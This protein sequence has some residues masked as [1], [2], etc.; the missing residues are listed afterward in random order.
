M[1]PHVVIKPD[2]AQRF[3]DAMKNGRVI[4]FSAPC[5]FGKTTLAKALLENY[6][7]KWIC[8]TEADYKIPDLDETGWDVL[9]VEQL[10]MIHD[11]AEQQNLCTLIRN[12]P[13]RR[14]VLLSRGIPQGWILPFQL[15]GLMHV[16][17]AFDLL[18]DRKTTEK[19]L[20]TFG[21]SV[22][23]SELTAIQKDSL[24]FPASIYFLGRLMEGGNPY[25]LLLA[26]DA[27]RDVYIYFEEA[28]YHRFDL[29]MRRFLLELA[30]FEQFGPE[31]A[32]MVSGDRH[33]GELLARLQRDTTMLLYDGVE[34]FHFWPDFR[35]YL[36]WEMNREYTTEQI[37]TL[38]NRGGL[39]YELKE[40]Y[41]RALECYTKSGD[42]S[43]ISEILVK[44][45]QLHPGTGYYEEMEQYYRALPDSE[46]MGSPSLMQGMSMLCAL[47]S[48]YEGSERWYYALL[49][50][51]A[52]RKR[53]DA[54]AKEAKSRLA[55]LDISLPQRKAE[56][57]LESI[58][59]AFRLMLAKEIELPPFSVTSLMPSVMNGG[60]DFSDWSKKDDLLYATMRKP[61]ESVLGK[62]GLGLAD[63]A[64][65]E[66]KFEKGED[67]SGRMLTLVSRLTDIQQYG[68]PSIEFAVVGL[69]ARS[70]IDTGHAED[71][72]RTVKSLR[73]R[74]EAQGETCFFPNMDAMLCRIAL[75]TGDLDYIDVWYRE[76]APKDPLHLR[77]MQRYQYFTQ[78][79]VE[80]FQGNYKLALL[81]L[82]PLE[83]YCEKCDRH[84]DEIYRRILTSIA[85][86]RLGDTNWKANLHTALDIAYEY[87]FIR[88][89]SQYGTAVLPLLERCR[90]KEDSDFLQG[91]MQAARMQAVYY[92]D[93]LRVQRELEEPLTSAEFQVLRLLCADKSNA[94]IGE[95]LNIKLATV[96]SHVSHILQKL[97]VKR[98]NEAKTAA[99]KFR[100]L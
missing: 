51:A 13:N 20:G 53:S 35:L 1:D 96:K 71:A 54:A 100:L 28:V 32:R 72:K 55:W 43:K 15:T 65:A 44:N 17:N 59:T 91:W 75:R 94:E 38:Y 7:C 99:E 40:D 57:V 50:F 41:V 64:I 97:G 95:I 19:L 5:G 30:P 90:W 66:S 81:T 80:I 70:Q 52:E 48:D 86:F 26:A 68:T 36:V 14:F 39:Y 56:G 92:P 98:R 6:H 69:L 2:I 84:L 31:L 24:G 45:A 67:I 61:V 33:A 21:V 47:C 62:D 4:F 11:P 22:S 46:I 16:F 25:T 42:H 12:S 27:R 49:N 29:P 79:M 93:F 58:T 74:F 77:V 37:Q 73:E 85:Q 3:R 34:E 89:I 87:R 23:S 10:Q 78:A 9:V 18:F 82:A 63:C 83:P 76:K 88:P 8:P 60:K